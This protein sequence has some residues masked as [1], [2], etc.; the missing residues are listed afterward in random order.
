MKELGQNSRGVK[1]GDRLYFINGTKM[2]AVLFE[3]F[4]LDHTEDKKIGDSIEKQ[5][6]F[7]EKGDL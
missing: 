1:I 7:V 4:F 5:R 6:A 3:S 2:T